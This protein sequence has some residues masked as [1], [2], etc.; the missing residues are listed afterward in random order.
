M[1]I[2]VG[3]FDTLPWVRGAHPLER[4]KQ[5]SGFGI[6]LLEF[7]SGFADP[8]WCERSHVIYMVEGAVEFEL[9]EGSARIGAGQCAV[10]DRGTRHRARN[11]SDQRAVAFI[12][13]DF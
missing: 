11:P 6:A 2:T 1:A 7:S 8:A 10:L 9:E 13:S 5:V 12:V 3:R 4:K